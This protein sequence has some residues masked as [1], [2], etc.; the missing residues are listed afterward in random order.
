MTALGGERGGAGRTSAQKFLRGDSCLMSS[1]SPPQ[2]IIFHNMAPS[3]LRKRK[4]EDVSSKRPSKKSRQQQQQH[5]YSSPSSSEADEDAPD[6]TPI[7]LADS[8]ENEDSPTS[9]TEGRADTLPNNIDPQAS[10]SATDSDPDS[11]SSSSTDSAASNSS[12]HNDNTSSSSRKT[13]KRNDPT[14]FATSISAILSSKLTTTKRADPVL[15]RSAIAQDANASLA[16]SKLEAKAKRKIRDDR[17]AALERGRVKD[18]LLGTTAG[19]SDGGGGEGNGEG[20]KSVGKLQEEERR[21]RKTAQRGVVKL[22]NAVRASQVKAE[23]ARA[24]GGTRGRKEERVEEMS[25]L[26]FLEM[27][28]SGGGSGKA[29]GKGNEKGALVGKVIEEA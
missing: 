3:I 18:V 7:R 8:S 5:H 26:G 11:S 4:H 6:F 15:A 20:E 27:V 28:A 21:L 29:K 22:F 14:A 19:V 13:Q 2:P 10:T 17:R 23:E 24:K 9:P 25:K 12:P 1:T 16:N